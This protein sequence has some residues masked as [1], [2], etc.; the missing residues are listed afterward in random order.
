MKI[1]ELLNEAPKK[2]NNKDDSWVK[3]ADDAVRGSFPMK[4]I[5]TMQGTI[6]RPGP[7]E[8]KTKK[9]KDVVKKK[10]NNKATTYKKPVQSRNDKINPNNIPTTSGFVDKRTEVGYEYEKDRDLWIPKK[11]GEQPLTGRE[12]AMRYNK[13]DSDKRYYVKETIIK[14]GGNIFQGTA[15]F[16]Q[17]LIPDM[18]KQINSVMAKTG[19]KAL[20]IGSGA[21]PQAGKMSGDLDMIADAGQL[22]KKFNAPDV[23][24]AKV[25]LEK[26]FQ[27]AGYETKKTGQIVHVKTTVGDVPQQVDIM[28]VDNGETASKFHVH[29][30]PGGSPYKGVHKQIMIADLAKDAGFKWSPYKGLVSRETNE[31]VSND[32]DNIAKQLIGPNATAKDLGSVESI[33]AKMP[34]AKEIIDRQEADPNSAWNKKKIQTQENEIVNA[35]RRI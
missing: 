12:G 30:I 16:D 28:V 2:T 4:A 9:T 23:K 31:L 29:D 33:V 19:V 15:D 35:L 10:K 18:M 24:T 14:E 5:Q 20:P 1:T 32:L 27:Q 3:K 26:M 8:I 22:I 6:G 21:S 17:K 7:A 13:T 34:S 25:E 11:N